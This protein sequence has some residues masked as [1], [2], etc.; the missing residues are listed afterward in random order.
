LYIETNPIFRWLPI[1]NAYES[2]SPAYF[3][4]PP[5]NLLYAYHASLSLITGKRTAQESNLPSEAVVS[6]EERF[7]LHKAASQKVK[8]AAKELGIGQIPQSEGEAANGMTAVRAP[9]SQLNQC[10]DTLILFS[11]IIP[12]A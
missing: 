3:A 11:C 9:L 10:A 6:L 4:T 8:S 2:G 12:M 1:M 5:V 7:A